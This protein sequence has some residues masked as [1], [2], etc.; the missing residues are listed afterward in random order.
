[1]RSLRLLCVLAA[2][3]TPS[4]AI[5]LPPLPSPP[6]CTLPSCIAL[7]GSSGGVPATAHGEFIVI[8]RD[9]ANNPMAGAA[10]TIDLSSAL[11]LHLCADQLDPQT[12]VNCGAKTT[13]KITAADG[14]VHFTVL[15]G[16]NGGGNA[17]TLL[18][19]GR[20]YANGA[21]LN[22]PTVSAYDMDGSGGVGANDMSAFLGD[23][24]TGQPFGR[25]DYDC[26]NSIGANDFSL[27]LGVFASGAMTESCGSSCP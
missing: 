11:D 14:S 25:S 20:I 17:N 1:M 18:N 24:S 15:G 4:L 22:R 13:R 9:L 26:S 12:T 6:N 27:W 10:V 21:L 2:L 19:G 7:V 8:V 23:F 3:A 16:S 5:A